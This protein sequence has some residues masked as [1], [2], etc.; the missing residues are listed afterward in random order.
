[1]VE[2]YGTHELGTIAW[3]CPRG[4]RLHVADDGVIVEVLNGDRPAEPGE[5]GEVVAT[6]L[7]ALAMPFIRYRLGDLVTRG[8]T[9]CP[10]GAPFSTL[11]TIQGRM[12]DYFPLPDGRLFHP[13]ELVTLI[14]EQGARWVGQYQISQERRDR[15]VV[16][17]APLTRPTAAEVVALESAARARLGPGIEVELALVPEIP[18]EVNGKFRV[19]RSFVESIHDGIDWDRRRADDIAAL[20]GGEPHDR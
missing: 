3:Q 19:S 10:C 2:L 4:M 14:L 11:L 12:L 16:R 13:Y 1:V 9:P 5:A 7:H 17:V 18:V 8:E 15:I 20:S 6:R